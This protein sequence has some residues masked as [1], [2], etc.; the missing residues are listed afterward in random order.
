MLNDAK[1]FAV[2]H[3]MS[4]VYVTHPSKVARA[5]KDGEIP[6]LHETDIRGGNT[7]ANGSDFVI[8][9]NRPYYFKEVVEDE[10]YGVVHGKNH[11]LVE[12]ITRKVKNQK[13]LKCRPN[14]IQLYFDKKKN[15]YN[16][17]FGFAPT[18][19]AYL[20][21]HADPENVD[22]F[23]QSSL[24]FTKEEEPTE[25]EIMNSVPFPT[26]EVRE[27]EAEEQEEVEGDFF[28]RYEELDEDDDMPF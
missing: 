11:P 28:D 22:Q 4:W 13:L 23:E 19:E 8:I 26:Q 12:F 9:I 18:D 17:E 24:N 20:K 2:R 16:N 27:E 6:V 1:I 21:Q 3:R 14:V 15:C 10:T 7:F 25:F 5:G